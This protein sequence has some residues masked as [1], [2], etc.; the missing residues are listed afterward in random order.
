MRKIR[1]VLLVVSIGLLFIQLYLADFSDFWKWST[2]LNILL[3]ILLIISLSGTII[4]TNK[5]RKDP[6]NKTNS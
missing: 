6:N 3:P 2:V 4:Y 1:Y 5:Q